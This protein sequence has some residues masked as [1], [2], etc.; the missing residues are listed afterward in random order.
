M[1]GK[2]NCGAISKGTEGD[3]Y[4]GCRYGFNVESDHMVEITFRKFGGICRKWKLSQNLSFHLA[5]V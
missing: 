2:V 1:V 5:Q 3:S 4:I